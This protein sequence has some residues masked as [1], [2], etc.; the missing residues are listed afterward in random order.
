VALFLGRIFLHVQQKF[1]VLFHPFFVGV[2]RE[3]IDIKDD[4]G[5]DRETPKSVHASRLYERIS[6]ALQQSNAQAILDFRYAEIDV[7]EAAQHDAVMGV[8]NTKLLS[9]ADCDADL[10][11]VDVEA[12][13]MDLQEELGAGGIVNGIEALA[14]AQAEVQAEAAS[15]SSIL[16]EEVALA[17]GGEPEGLGIASAGVIASVLQFSGALAVVAE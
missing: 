14:E 5:F 1:M 12:V 4:S 6:V 10:L 3:L 13:E 8:L 2:L 16:E 11:Q 9:L 15:G 7:P 17:G